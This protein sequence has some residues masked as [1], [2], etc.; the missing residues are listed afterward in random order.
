LN[1]E[2]R[3]EE[4]PLSQVPKKEFKYGSKKIHSEAPAEMW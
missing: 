2:E 1:S 4:Q 3:G